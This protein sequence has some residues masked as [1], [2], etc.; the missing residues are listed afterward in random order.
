MT[1]RALAMMLDDLAER[2]ER[3]AEIFEEIDPNAHKRLAKNYRRQAARHTSKAKGFHY[4]ADQEDAAL[5]A[6]G[7][8]RET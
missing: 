5:R 4:L 6:E 1:N 2:S 8:L 3:L 7:V